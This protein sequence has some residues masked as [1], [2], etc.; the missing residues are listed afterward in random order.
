MRA[1]RL[2]VLTT[3]ASAACGGPE[4]ASDR[5]TLGEGA[6]PGT[7]PAAVQAPIDSGNVA[8]RGGDYAAALRYYRTA[9]ERAPDD[10][11]PWIGVG[12]AA[13]ALDDRPLLDSANARISQ[14]A[15][16]LA[17]GAHPAPGSESAPHP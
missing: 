1:H 2:I 15:P 10:V 9:A 14:L 13:G 16:D 11:T 12:M 17:P 4:R 6:G 8:Y 5:V 7:L 3:L